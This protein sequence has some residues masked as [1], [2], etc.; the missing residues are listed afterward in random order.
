MAAKTGA[1]KTGGAAKTVKTAAKPAART[2]KS[3]SK[4][5]KS[6]A[7]TSK[8]PAAKTAKK[9]APRKTQAPAETSRYG[10]EVC[11]LVVSVDEWG[12]MNFVN[13]VCCGE[14]MK[15]A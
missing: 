2:V 13:L 1:K 4:A 3:P 7:K 5:A 8:K 10:C 11:G 9:T 12:D 15:P 6:P 14:Q